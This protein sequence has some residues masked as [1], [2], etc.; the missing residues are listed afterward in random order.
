MKR[1]LLALAAAAALAITPVLAAPNGFQVKPGVFD[2]D[3][4]G[5][6]QAAW[7]TGQG[8]PDA[9]NSNHA[10]YL[11]KLGPTSAYA[12]AGATVEGVQGIT[13]SQLGF[14]YQ[15]DGHCGAGAPRI[16]VYTATT[17]HFFGCIYGVHTPAPDNPAKWTRV[18]FTPADAFPPLLPT[19]PITGMEVI[20]DEGT[21]S[22]QGFVYLD[23]IDVNGTLIGKPGL[24]KP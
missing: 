13:V 7:V 4:T 3:R 17:T 24:T 5:I 10:L 8:L 22:G 1:T 6:V 20:F 15:N 18:R 21:D 2:P 11:A 14:D 9:G 19:T 16:N 23:N 12:A